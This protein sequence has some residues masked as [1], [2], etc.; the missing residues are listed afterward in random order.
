MAVGSEMRKVE[1]FQ[2]FVKDWHFD[3]MAVALL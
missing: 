2:V 3:E 1:L